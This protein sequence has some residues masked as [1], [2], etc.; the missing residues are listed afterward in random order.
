MDANETRTLMRI[1]RAELHGALLY[2]RIAARARNEEE[3]ETLLSIARD[4]HRHAAFFAS[5]SGRKARP[6]MF[7]IRLHALFA[8]V[9]GYTFIIRLLERDEDRAV[10]GYKA[11]LRDLPQLDAFLADEER[12]ED[13]L[14]DI[15]D[16][17]R[18]HYM[19]DIVLGINDALV[20]LTGSLAGYTL[21]LRDTKVIAMAG[22]IT[23]ISATLSMAS[24]GYLSSR[25]QGA[26]DARRSALY[27]GVAYLVT[28]ALLITPYLLLP[29]SAYLAA[30]GAALVIAVAIIAAF[31]YYTA[32][33]RARP[34]RRGFLTMAGISLGVAAI[35]FVIGLLV[36]NVLGIEL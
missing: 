34:F 36:R 6:P 26:R 35:S 16:E 23:G 27:T 15:L 31:N 17:E 2:E 20:E 18:L 8:R 32:V 19:S 1:Q 9:F 3:R 24:S 29:A 30:L 11:L 14:I 21:A 28:V 4:E 13:A 25:E 33:S 22:L 7:L 12:H 10:A 5:L